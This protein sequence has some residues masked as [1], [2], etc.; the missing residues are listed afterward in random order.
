MNSRERQEKVRDRNRKRVQRE[1]K[2]LKYFHCHIFL[3]TSFRF[4]ITNDSSAHI[5]ETMC[6]IRI[7]RS[8]SVQNPIQFKLTSCLFKRKYL[9]LFSFFFSF[10]FF[11]FFFTIFIFPFL[12]DL[13]PIASPGDKTYVVWLAE[14]LFPPQSL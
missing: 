4:D 6:R 12:S 14:R 10:F 11:Y 3:N 1:K 9:H 2:K 13:K 7:Q 8:F 5:N